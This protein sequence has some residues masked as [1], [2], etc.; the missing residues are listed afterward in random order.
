MMSDATRNPVS[1]TPRPH[2]SRLPLLRE[3]PLPRS[4]RRFIDDREIRE[5][6]GVDVDVEESRLFLRA[7]IALQRLNVRAIV[8]VVIEILVVG[9]DIGVVERRGLLV[10]IADDL[11]R[12][13]PVL[14]IER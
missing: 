8:G 1:L 6:F 13:L 7:H 5:G 11:E 10:E 4:L 2:S 12:R 14:G 3:A 9:P